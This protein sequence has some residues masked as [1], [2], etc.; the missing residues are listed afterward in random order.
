MVPYDDY[1]YGFVEGMVT[2]FTQRGFTY[3]NDLPIDEEHTEVS[4]FFS[5]RGQTPIELLLPNI[6]CCEEP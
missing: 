3:S 6:A 1:D 4:T 5:E 2:T